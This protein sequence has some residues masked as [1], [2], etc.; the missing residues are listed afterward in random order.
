MFSFRIPNINKLK[1]ERKNS[2]FVPFGHRC[3]SAVILNFSSLRKYS[4]PFD[5]T[6]PSYPKKIQS[7]IENNFDN[8]IPDVQNNIFCNKYDIFLAHFNKNIREGIK[9]YERR[10]ERFKNIMREDKYFYFIYFNEDYLYD[11]KYRDENFSQ[12]LF[13]EMLELE[14]YIKKKYN[15]TNYNILYF[16]FIE[17]KVP[18]DSNIINIVINTKKIWNDPKESEYAKLRIFCAKILSMLF[19]TNMSIKNV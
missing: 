19:N 16:D 7:V 1:I 5:W 2:N 14:K 13:M 11:E 8:F 15:I 18:N 17:Y 10:I 9:Q 12:N 4:L 6:S 3:S